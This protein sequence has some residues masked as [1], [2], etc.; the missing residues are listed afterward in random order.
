MKID[1]HGLNSEEA[2]I[3]IMG[4][5]LS[6]DMSYDNELEIISGKGQGVMLLLTQKI[7]DEEQRDY[8]VKEGRIIVYK[9][10]ENY[11]SLDFDFDE[12]LEE[13]KN[14]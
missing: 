8:L 7:L 11:D 4:A 5:L 9:N 3:E 12:V 14:K 6:F 13:L 1:L 2:T 10:N